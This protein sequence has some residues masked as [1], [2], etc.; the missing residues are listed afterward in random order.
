MLK[1]FAIGKLMNKLLEDAK[2]LITKNHHESID[3]RWLLIFG[4]VKIMV[5]R[6]GM[7]P[8]AGHQC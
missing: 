2:A 7:A 6:Y 3:L 8:P 1:R 5:C 4:S